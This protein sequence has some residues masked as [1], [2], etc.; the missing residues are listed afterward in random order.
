MLVMA[1][2]GA[3]QLENPGRHPKGYRFTDVVFSKMIVIPETAQG[4]ETQFRLLKDDK[5]CNQLTTF[6]NFR[7]YMYDQGE[8]V[9]CSRGSLVVEYQEADSGFHQRVSQEHGKTQQLCKSI[10]VHDNFYSHLRDAGLDYGPL[11]RIVN[12]IGYGEE[13][14]GIGVIDTQRAQSLMGDRPQPPYLIHPATLDCIFQVAFLGITR[15]GQIDIPALVPTEI[16]ELWI[17]GGVS[18]DFH[19]DSLVQV[20]V[21]SFP[22]GSRTHVANY[23][24]LWR[25]EAGPL[26]VGDITL[27]S[28]GRAKAIEKKVEDPISLYHVEWK[29]DVNLL[30]SSS[31]CLTFLSDHTE[32]T[33]PDKEQISLTEYLCYLTMSEVLSVVDGASLPFP[34]KTVHLQKYLDW[35]RHQTA[36]M[37]DCETW[38]NFVSIQPQDPES[39]EQLSQ[40]VE[41]FGPEGKIISRLS[42]VL[43][44]IVQSEVDALP[45]LFT[46][47][48]LAEYYRLENPSPE[49]ARSV[50]NYVDCLAHGNPQLRVL[51]IGGGTGGMTRG[52]LDSL[53]ERFSE[54]RFTDISPAFFRSATERF[55][56]EGFACKTLNIETDPGEQGF[57]LE[58]YD[59]VIAS[60]VSLLGRRSKTVDF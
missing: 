35:M 48:T 54:Y 57:D 46:D 58:S 31:K 49:V 18:K 29:P 36:L 60:N 50:Q 53:G 42:R 45:V 6:Y 28:I 8:W 39:R 51:E 40:K 44:Q 38:R 16:K 56:R 32:S 13:N 14:S 7:L 2:E 52:V 59:L 25:N 26:L 11:F 10:A 19:N 12:E 34:E 47:D 22:T 24:S 30:S 37:Q 17:S 41:S 5:L 15:G 21:Q 33:L 55:G 23:T 27:T 9:Q 4:V 20:A 3:Q 43:L 1:I